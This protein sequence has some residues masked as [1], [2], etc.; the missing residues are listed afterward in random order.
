MVL[1]LCRRHLGVQL[2]KLFF[3]EYLAFV[4]IH[5]GICYE[6]LNMEYHFKKPY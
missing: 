5:P 2:Y 1:R 3:A 6:V 4:N